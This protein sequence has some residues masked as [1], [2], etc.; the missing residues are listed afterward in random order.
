M[1]GERVWADSQRGVAVITWSYDA[2]RP[3]RIK[4]ASIDQLVTKQEVV[5][6][7]YEY[8]IGILKWQNSHFIIEPD[9]I[10]YSVKA[11]TE[12]LVVQARHVTSLLYHFRNKTL[13]LVMR[14]TLSPLSL[15]LFPPPTGWQKSSHVVPPPTVG[16][17]S[18]DVCIWEWTCQC[19]GEV[20]GS[21]GWSWPSRSSKKPGY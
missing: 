7:G 1:Y 8:G 13:P 6:D 15:V 11:T 2:Y 5:W 18:S 9:G 3:L 12:N 17:N 19:C 20:T 14:P 16:Q 4:V 10:C 21:R